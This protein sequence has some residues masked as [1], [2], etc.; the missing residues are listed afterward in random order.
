MNP[1][2]IV[3]LAV[4]G[5]FA[6]SL[7]MGSF[8][9]VNPGERGVLVTMGKTSSD[10]L[11]EG[12][13]LKMPFFS[14]IRN[15]S[16]RVQNSESSADAATKDLQRIHAG[17]ALNWRINPEKVAEMYQQIGDETAIHDRIISPAVNEVLKASTAKMTAEE[18]LTR[19]LE[20]KH[21][22]DNLLVERLKQYNVIVEQINLVQLNFTKEFNDAI[23]SKQVAEQDAKRAEYVAQKAKNDAVAA[24]NKARGEAE[25]RLIEARAQSEGQKLLQTTVTPMILQLKAIEKWDGTVPQ[26]MGT[27]SN[28][29]FNIPTSS[30]APSE[31]K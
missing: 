13:H 18:V 20:L 11:T 17:V 3:L 7:F 29:L 4:G 21:D 23:E 24:V 19:R 8:Q 31:A 28:M 14:Y 6:F 9:V 26:V 25:S 16:V 27:G 2:K 1:V 12:V 15:I 22:I 10:V 5:I 30:R